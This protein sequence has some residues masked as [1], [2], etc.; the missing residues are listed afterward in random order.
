[1]SNMLSITI[2]IP[3]YRRCSLLKNLINSIFGNQIVG[4]QLQKIN[5]IV[6]DN[7]N[8]SSARSTIED[9]RIIKPNIFNL[10]YYSYPFKGLANVRN[11]LLKRGLET[12][13]DYLVFVDDD[14]FV[15]QNW[16]YELIHCVESN[17]AEAAR[18][19]VLAFNTTEMPKSIACWFKRE[20]FPDNSQVN[21]FTT[22]NLIIKASTLVKHNVWFDKRLNH[23]GGEDTF[24]GVQLIK[25]GT[26]IYWAANAIAYEIIPPHRAGLK[27][28]LMR[29]YR[30][31]C[32]YTY[33][34][35]IEKQ[36]FALLKKII[37]SLIYIIIGS[38]ASI[39]VIS[40]YKKKYWGLLKMVEGAGGIYGAFGFLYKEYK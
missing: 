16:L 2:C 21:T 22:G 10:Y 26:K 6:V 11:E 13:A 17:N 39:A 19:P 34:L 12:E 9:S 28:L 36:R 38:I 27:W 31:A 40:S 15:T 37:V 1:M 30:V 29:K 18:G 3:T 35:R 8:K 5:I 4:L 14:E 33:I 32:I 24:W 23:T 20:S 7:D 25:K